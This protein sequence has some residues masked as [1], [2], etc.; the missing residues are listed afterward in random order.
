MA[1]EDAAWRRGKE[2]GPMP[3]PVTVSSLEDAQAAKAANAA[4]PGFRT[5][6]FYLSLAVMVCAL[7]LT[8]ADKIGGEAGLGAI[9]A[10][11]VG[12]AVSRGIAK[13]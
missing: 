10:A 4:A 6:E 7:V 3:G 9:T 13:T 8:L 2:P 12:Y 5:S 1:K 11:G